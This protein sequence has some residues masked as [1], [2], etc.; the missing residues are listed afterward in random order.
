MS[1]A[2]HHARS[3]EFASM[4]E[5]A[6]HQQEVGRSV[7]LYQSAAEQ[8]TLAL[9]ELDQNK[10]R[11]LGITTVSAASL[12]YKATDYEKAQQIVY[13]GLANKDLPAF[14]KKQLEDLLQNLWIER[15]REKAGINFT[16]GEVLISVS[17][18]EIVRGGAPLELIIQ[19][20]DEVGRIFYRTIE[21][22]LGYPFRKR[23]VPSPEIQEQFRPW[24][25]QAPAGSY[26]FS[27]RVEKPKQMS[28]FPEAT[29][30]VNSI[31]TTFLDILRASADDPEK[32]LAKIVPN[33]EYRDIFLKL[34]R[35][36]APTGKVFGRMEIKPSS[37][38]GR[39][40]V[41]LMPASREVMSHA[42]KTS[43]ESLLGGK[44]REEIQISGTLRGLQ[45]DK[46]W[47]DVDTL[48]EEP[49]TIRVYN[50]R[51]AIDDVVGP[52]VNHKVI[53]SVIKKTSGKRLEFRDIQTDE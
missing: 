10:A 30:S 43:R 38:M 27:V 9:E 11:T 12:W 42:L 3:E 24:L 33:K 51:E 21:L 13:Q 20:V 48:D 50:A 5:V 17:G 35:N 18:G 2:E 22:L 7:E 19:K 44:D 49:K 8:E 45:L 39:Q 29:P 14:A 25:F 36:L 1:W 16:T 37:D 6:Y 46:D 41:V 40:R 31:T 52:M 32:E 53:V 47:L 15:D 34:T 4:A 28:L 23:G 26:Q